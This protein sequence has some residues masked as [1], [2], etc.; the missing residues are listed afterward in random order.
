MR[1]AIYARVSDPR[2]AEEDKASLPEQLLRMENYCQEKGY[3]IVDRYVDAGYSGATTKRPE[4]QRMLQDARGKRFNVVVC[5]KA[6]RLSRGMYPAAALMEAIELLG[7]TI[8][9][10]EERFDVNMFAMLAVVGK[11]E[12]DNI[13]ARTRMGREARAKRGKFLGGPPYGYD[14]DTE[15]GTL[16]VNPE[17]AEVVCEIFSLYTEGMPVAQIVARLNARGI[18]TKKNS[19]L[20]WAHGKVTTMVSRS[21]YYGEG[22]FTTG[23]KGKPTRISLS[24]PAIVSRETFERA[25]AR[26]E[27][28]KRFSGRKTK[29][30]YLLQ[31]LVF[32][33]ECGKRFHIIGL[34]DRYGYYVCRGMEVYPHVYSCRR[35]KGI[36]YRELDGLVWDKVSEIM[37]SPGALRAAMELRATSLKADITDEQAQYKA[38]K[39]KIENLKLEQQWVITQTRK[40]K[41]TEEQMDLQLRAVR[42][43]EEMWLEDLHKIEAARVIRLRQEDILREAQKVCEVLKGR[44]EALS[45]PKAITDE[46][47]RRRVLQERQ[48]IVRLLVNRV[49]VDGQGEVT[50]EFAVPELMPVE[51]SDLCFDLSWSRSNGW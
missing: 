29:R 6:D 38:A 48:A 25:Q 28:N 10:V 26:K 34:S 22:Y 5:W 11:M 12:L 30:I 18:P 46:E 40:G 42:A 37:T 21:L 47:E 44:V 32:C 39:D 31:H 4:F 27:T 3:T 50:I 9:A 15:T 41:I 23:P 51:D 1:A 17:E 7:I 20:G 36:P 14:Y 24:Y 43:E 33:Q 49:L 19:R 13:K 35:P 8:E 2:Q 45:N 16:K